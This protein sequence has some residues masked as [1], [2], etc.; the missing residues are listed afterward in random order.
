MYV[1]RDAFAIRSSI[2]N[3]CCLLSKSHDF[4]IWED[5]IFVKGC[6][7]Q[8][9]FYFTSLKL[10]Q[11]SSWGKQE[12]SR[13]DRNKNYIQEIQGQKRQQTVEVQ[14]KIKAGLPFFTAVV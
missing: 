8:I 12:V 13:S 1:V 6:A 11:A 10:T 2:I 3:L 14:T 7:H 4:T 9:F 5:E